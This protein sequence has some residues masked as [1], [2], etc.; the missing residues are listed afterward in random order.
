[1]NEQNLTFIMDSLC[2]LKWNFFL[3][4]LVSVYFFASCDRN[5][6]SEIKDE[7]F[8][9][10]SV[11][12]LVKEINEKGVYCYIMA[13]QRDSA[14]FYFEKAYELLDN[15]EIKNHYYQDYIIKVLIN[16]ADCYQRDGNFQMSGFYYR[17]ALF[18]SDSI[19]NENVK[20]SIFSGLARLYS[21]IE[22]FELADEYFLKAEN[23][24]DTGNGQ[25]K[26]F[27]ANSRGNYYY[28]TK[29]YEQALGW[30][31]KAYNMLNT[32]SDKISN[33]IVEANLGE[34]FILINQPDSARYYLDCSKASWG[35]SYVQPSVNFYIEGLYASLA[36]LEN[37]IAEAERLLLQEN[38]KDGIIPQYIYFHNRRMQLLY[39][40]KND[41]RNAYLFKTKAD[42]YDDS[43]RNIKVQNNIAE[44]AFRYQ[45]D[46]SLFKKDLQIA[47]TELEVSQ[48]R[49]TF[50]F[51]IFL[52]IIVLL[53]FY[54]F[55]LYK[56]RSREL[57]YSRQLAT[58]NTL[59]MEIIRNRISPHYTFNVLNAIMPA[60]G[61]YEEL[62]SPFRLLIQMLRS[63][64]MA[65]EKISVLLNEEIDL[66]KNYLQ[67]YQMSHS[68]RV[69][70]CWEV[71]DDISEYFQIPSMAIQIPVENALKYA[72]TDEMEHPL[73]NIKIA[74]ENEEL[75]I[76]IE[77]NGIGFRHCE[78]RSDE[79]GTGYGLRML[80]NTT[81]L[82]NSRNSRKMIFRVQNNNGTQVFIAI[83][84]DF[85]FDM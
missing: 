13:D 60:L 85:K 2:E 15:S 61:E 32:Y 34:I 29:E 81:E 51:S 73:I 12:L 33:A 11:L 71:A 45:Q 63:N 35:D 72:F 68:G 44:M 31:R 23:Y 78:K 17:R 37:K 80:Y 66:V 30:F 19:N 39:E 21:E 8:Y 3:L 36:L 41:Y 57:K 24:Y 64:L 58:I 84:I 9:S 67:L 49:N 47:E 6:L 28:S 69:Q 65:S 74:F 56:K 40:K 75:H 82:L 76:S 20:F 14:I 38:S 48:W 4:L 59:R 7:V 79:R 77:D 83:P 50:L 52:F 5:N 62:E 16:M 10:D 55:Y 53:V 27:F 22:N 43:L 26:H 54:S 42:L 18:L 70:I 1:M 25:E 46:T